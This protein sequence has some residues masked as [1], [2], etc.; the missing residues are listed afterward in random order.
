MNWGIILSAI[1]VSLFKQTYQGKK[2]GKRESN[3]MSNPGGKSY[4]RDQTG[5]V[6]QKGEVGADSSDDIN[7]Q[8][9]RI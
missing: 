6:L 7:I 9:T 3:E 5:I 1:T 8:T 4:A 2:L